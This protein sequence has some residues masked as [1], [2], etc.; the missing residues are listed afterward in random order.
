MFFFQDFHFH[1]FLPFFLHSIH[2]SQDFGSGD[3]EPHHHSHPVQG[4]GRGGSTN[5]GQAEETSSTPASPPVTTPKPEPVQFLRF[6]KKLS[7]VTRDSGSS[8]KL[9]CVA[10]GYPPPRKIHWLRNSVDIKSS[11]NGRIRIRKYQNR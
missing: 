10:E 3:K 9:R 8:V 5:H 11:R 1:F 2:R 6:I 7:N 4:N